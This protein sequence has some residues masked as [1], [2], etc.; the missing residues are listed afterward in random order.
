MLLKKA[1]YAVL[2]VAL[3]LTLALLNLPTGAASRLKRGVAST[4]LPWFGLSGSLQSAIDRL[5]WAA[6]PRHLLVAEVQRLEQTNALLHL[7]LHQASTRASQLEAVASELGWSQ[8][9]PWKLKAARVV[10]RDPATWWRTLQIDYGTRDGAQLNQTV[11]VPSG[12]VGR[13]SATSHLHSHVALV[14]DAECGVS[15][16]VRET[17]D[18]G[19][20][21]GPQ[22]IADHGLV[23]MTTLQNNPHLLAGQTVVTSGLGRIF[24]AGIPVGRIVDTRPAEGGLYS[25][26]R[27][28]LAV[29]LNQLDHVWI[30]QP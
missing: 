18:L 4:L 26:A 7:A 2:G 1:Q 15:T 30:I 23:E 9:T 14:G 27:I 6:V 20:I 19:I 3:G 17:R 11:L 5:S 24:P 22:S 25:A 13:I 8:A 12:L 28:Q 10:A 29:N 21:R 16:L